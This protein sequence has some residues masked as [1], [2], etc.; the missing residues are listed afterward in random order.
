[1]LRSDLLPIRME[2]PTEV[3]F[4]RPVTETLSPIAQTASQ[5]LFAAAQGLLR[6]GRPN[7]FGEWSIADVDLAVML[8][9]LILSGD[10]VPTDLIRYAGG[11]WQRPSVQ[12]WVRIE[13]PPLT[14]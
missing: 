8:N 3:I 9:R 10:D 13:R 5:K 2:R 4:Y 6:H 1:V 7:L 12:R 11:Q 14:T